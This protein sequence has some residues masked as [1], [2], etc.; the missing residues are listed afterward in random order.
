MYD[1]VIAKLA[2][3]MEK[4][5]ESLK[6]EFAKVRTGRASASL[7]D[8]V[9]VDYYGNPTPLNQVGTISVPEARLITV[10]PWE[11]N[12]IP[13][14]EKAIFKADL[15]LNP[16]SDGELVRIAIPPLTEDRRKEMCK[17]A[18][19]MGE[20]AKIAI[21]NARRD[22]NEG[23]KKLEKE[24]EITEDDLKR[25]EKEIQ[26]LTDRFVKKVDDMVSAKEE[27]VMEI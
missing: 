23:M 8:E 9:K 16:S 25:G 12:L 20:D 17:L 18:K 27:E 24:K 15:G 13:E 22:G 21:R 26:E 1:D 19:K 3:A 11:K 14:I 5:L 2:P 4:S 6:R 10:S 7:L